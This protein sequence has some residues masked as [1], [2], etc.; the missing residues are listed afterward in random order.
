MPQKLEKTCGIVLH[1]KKIGEAH[2]IV[3]LLTEEDALLALR[4]HNIYLSKK[5]SRLLTQPASRIAIDYYTTSQNISSA[6]EGSILA[7][8][9]PTQANYDDLLIMSYL[10]DLTLGGAK[11]G[12]SQGLYMLIQGS[13]RTLCQKRD[14]N[15]ARLALVIFFQVRLLKILGLLGETKHCSQC[16]A[17]LKRQAHWCLPEMRFLC[18]AC[19]PH[20]ATRKAFLMAQTVAAASSQRFSVF[21]DS[22]KNKK[23]E[24]SFHMQNHCNSLWHNLNTCLENFH[25]KPFASAKQFISGP[26]LAPIL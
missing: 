23:N 17:P 10:L 1:R 24:N 12:T 5:R 2:S 20:K 21:Y 15:Q 13:L 3:Q 8:F 7:A 25:G 4:F 22:G 9:H 6:K 11:Y 18:Q 26:F 14:D 16:S 19:A